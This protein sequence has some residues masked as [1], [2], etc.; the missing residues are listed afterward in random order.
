MQKSTNIR[1]VSLLM[2][3]FLPCLMIG[4]NNQAAANGPQAITKAQITGEE[5]G[6]VVY[7]SGKWIGSDGLVYY[8]TQN[9]HRFTW[10]VASTRQRCS[11]KVVGRNMTVKWRV[12]KRRKK[13]PVTGKITEINIKGKALRIEWSNGIIFDREDIA[14]EP[15]R[16]EIITK[17]VPDISIVKPEISVVKPMVKLPETRCSEMALISCSLAIKFVLGLMLKGSLL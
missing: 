6:K 10:T 13:V 5:T 9:R 1:L 17:K 14:P 3:V 15:A 2:I 4:G 11:G 7:I 12:G 16:P 8:I